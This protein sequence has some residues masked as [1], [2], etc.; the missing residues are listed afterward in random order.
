[1]NIELADVFSTKQHR[2]LSQES[3]KLIQA[4]WRYHQS[5]HVVHFGATLYISK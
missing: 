2:S 4:H 3:Y 1:M 5:N